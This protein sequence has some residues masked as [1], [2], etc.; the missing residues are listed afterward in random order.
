[1][2][3]GTANRREFYLAKIKEAEGIA[4]RSKDAQVIADMQ[5]VIVGYRKLLA[6]LPPESPDNAS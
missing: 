1:M 2:G 4:A 5:I 3:G 6:R